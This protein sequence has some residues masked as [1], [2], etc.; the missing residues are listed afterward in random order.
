VTPA[1][2]RNQKAVL[3]RQR[4]DCGSVPSIRLER[5]ITDMPP[6]SWRADA[7]PC[8]RVPKEKPS[9]NIARGRTASAGFGMG[10]TE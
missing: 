4:D 5:S 10:N 7:R 6:A 8:R 2:S 3:G 1:G 9:Y